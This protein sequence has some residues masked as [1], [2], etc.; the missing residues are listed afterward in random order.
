M[1]KTI[2]S[3]FL[4][5]VFI[6]FLALASAQADWHHL[7]KMNAAAPQG[8]QI[9]FRNPESTVVVTVLAPDLVRVRMVPGSVLPPDY[10]WAVAKTDWPQPSF[11][12]S[13]SG[14]TRVIRT[15]EL[16]VRIDLQPF[17]IAF[18]NNKGELIA[19]D[20][21]GMAWDGAR[22]RC[23]KSMPLGE[24]YYGLGE[25]AGPVAKR[26]HSYVMWNTDPAAYDAN[27]D[28][29]YQSVPFF[30]ALR[31]GQAYGLFFDN[32]YRS[33]FDMGVEST[34]EYSFG[35]DGGEMNYYFFYG[36]DPKKVIAR[37]R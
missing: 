19:K 23:W 2:L 11:E 12:F 27:T 24:Q 6:I 18:Y 16:E 28:P 5:T 14:E 15:S 22:V 9:P 4:R 10:S 36:P 17:R 1:P 7:G 32:T 31:K 21:R 25:K 13:G 8:H 33:S 20:A 34:E 26:G 35:A 30:I 29:M 3:S 37:D